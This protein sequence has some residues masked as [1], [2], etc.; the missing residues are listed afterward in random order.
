M[1]TVADYAKKRKVSKFTVYSW[2]YKKKTKENGFEVIQVGN[3]KLINP[4]KK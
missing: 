1:I 3:V 2:I 4:I